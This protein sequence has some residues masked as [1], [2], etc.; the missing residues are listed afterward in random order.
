MRLRVAGG[1][2]ALRILRAHRGIHVGSREAQE[3]QS[4]NQFKMCRL[5]GRVASPVTSRLPMV[6]KLATVYAFGC[7]CE[8]FAIRERPLRVESA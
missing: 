1:G 6:G 3:S 2:A 7:Q 4:F 5:L 8:D